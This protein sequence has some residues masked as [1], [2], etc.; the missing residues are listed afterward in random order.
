MSSLCLSRTLKVS[1]SH[2]TLLL[3]I[4][5][6]VVIRPPRMLPVPVPVVLVLIVVLVVVIIPRRLAL[7]EAVQMA[8]EVGVVHIVVVLLVRGVFGL[9]GCGGWRTR[10]RRLDLFSRL[11]LLRFLACVDPA[12]G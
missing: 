3:I 8:A 1:L 9:G 6:V 11:L 5:V 10:A 2:T 4:I 12:G 7:A